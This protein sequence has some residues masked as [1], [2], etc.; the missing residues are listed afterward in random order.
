[1]QTTLR[2]RLSIPPS[3]ALV[4]GAL[5]RA[6]HVR[7]LA[8]IEGALEFA[9]RSGTHGP[10]PGSLLELNT[11]DCAA[12][13]RVDARARRARLVSLIVRIPGVDGQSLGG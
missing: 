5:P 11:R 9:T 12:Q 7:V 1:M 6:Q 3:V 4:V 10:R 2:Y 8:A 13:L